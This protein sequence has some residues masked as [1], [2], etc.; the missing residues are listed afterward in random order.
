MLYTLN[1]YANYTSFEEKDKV[2]KT[3]WGMLFLF[4][5]F[6]CGSAISQWIQALV[7]QDFT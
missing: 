7:S 2:K 1:S 6:I 3:K 4:G 5:Y